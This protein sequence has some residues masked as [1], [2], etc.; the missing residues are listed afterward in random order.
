MWGN[1]HGGKRGRKVRVSHGELGS[2]WRFLD[3]LG[4][5]GDAVVGRSGGWKKYRWI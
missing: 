1:G 3:A 4:L 2:S 5:S